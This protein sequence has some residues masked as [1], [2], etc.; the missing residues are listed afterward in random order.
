MKGLLVASATHMLVIDSLSQN[1]GVAL[2]YRL[3]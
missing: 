2:G 1:S 3:S